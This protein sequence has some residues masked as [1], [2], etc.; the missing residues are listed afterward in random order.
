MSEEFQINYQTDFYTSEQ[1]LMLK[2]TTINISNVGTPRFHELAPPPVV[3][4][5]KG[6]DLR[7]RL[8]KLSKRHQVPLGMVNLQRLAVVLSGGFQVLV[9]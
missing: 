4:D 2:S 6:Q 9:D 7:E 1:L 3:H 5:A 8:S